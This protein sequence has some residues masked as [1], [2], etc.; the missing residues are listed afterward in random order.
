MERL[1][2]C[3]FVVTL[4]RYIYADAL[5]NQLDLLCLLFGSFLQ[6]TDAEDAEDFTFDNGQVCR[7]LNGTARV[8]P[9]ITSFYLVGENQEKLTQDMETKMQNET[10]RFRFNGNLFQLRIVGCKVYPQGYAAIVQQLADFE[11]EHLLADI[12]N[13]T[14][15]L[16]YLT[17]SQP[18]E[19][20]CWTEK[21]GVN[22][23]MIRAKEA[24]L[25]RFGSKIS[26]ST[27]EQILRTG[28]AKIDAD[29]LACIREVASG[30]V[31]ELFAALRSYEYD[32]ATTHLTIVGGGGQLVKHFGSYDPEQVTIVDDIC[33]AAKGYEYM[34]YRQMLRG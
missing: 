9:K 1:D 28:T 7:W 10:I 31:A 30:Y 34:A 6:S 19:S 33:A 32:P 29:Y 27:V 15:N 25:R 5:G 26:D 24:V 17:D 21:I 20:R 13:G 18:Q 4:R 22:Q 11:G 8:S 3:S 16:L 23:C 2:F 14:M 12:G